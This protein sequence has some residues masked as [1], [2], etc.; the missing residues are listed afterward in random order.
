M[1]VCE[2]VQN[3]ISRNQAREPRHVSARSG[4]LRDRADAA[5]NLVHA[6]DTARTAMLEQPGGSRRSS[7]W[8]QVRGQTG[9]S[10]PSHHASP[11]AV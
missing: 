2:C 9:P 1:E 10:P 3:V 7:E 5:G 6:R 4:G 8:R 11:R